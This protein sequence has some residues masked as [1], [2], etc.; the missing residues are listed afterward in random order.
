MPWI[1]IMV[2]SIVGV[3]IGLSLMGISGAVLYSPLVVAIYGARSGNGIMFLPFLVA[4]IYVAYKYRKNFDRATVLKL[5][6]FSLV[7]MG[8]ASYYANIIPDELFR[9]IL[10][11]IIVGASIL[12]FLKK[13]EAKLTKMGWLFGVLGGAASY[14][15]N[16]SGPIF[17]VYLLSYNRDEENFIG[18]RSVFFMFLNFLKFFL[19]F[20]IYKNINTYTLSRGIISVPTIFV[21]VYLGKLLLSKISQKTFNTTIVV[22]SLVVA[23]K[24]IFF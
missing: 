7:G 18:T 19:Y 11:I 6:P 23:V 4:D 5:I 9:K 14:L 1:D 10:G 8:I 2:L 15:A 3:G 20:F 16:I 17:N 22:L 13:Y 21:G 24:L 12:Y